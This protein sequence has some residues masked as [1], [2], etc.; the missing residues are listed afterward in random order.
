MRN[1]SIE[2]WLADSGA[3][4]TFVESL[5]LE[6]IDREA[7][8][9]NQARISAPIDEDTVITYAVAMENGD[10]F[11]PLVVYQE[12]ENG[13]YINVDGNH[14]YGAA[15]MVGKNRLPSYVVTNPTPALVSLLTYNANT[16]HGKP[17]TLQERLR[18]ATVLVEMGAAPKEIAANLQI[19]LRSLYA[20]IE[21][22]NT[23]K[24]M[25]GL[26][27]SRWDTIARGVRTRLTNV[28]SDRVL[29]AATSLV[30][31]AKL[32]SA[33]VNDLVTE[34][35]KKRNES[36]QMKVVAAWTERTAPDVAETGGGVIPIPKPIMYITQVLTRLEN[37]KPEHLDEAN[38]SE[39]YRAR[40]V[41]KVMAGAAR[42]R[43]VADRIG[44][45]NG[46]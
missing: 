3:Q 20:H 29:K 19:P 15:Q 24:R 21:Q 41:Q 34:V 8:Y 1:E 2:K 46:A 32:V 27:I 18:Q 11:P 39:E 28:R 35:N 22:V 37:I 12:K 45:K 31:R 7:S 25:Q 14:R 43:E 38:L 30:L 33:D 9:R 44:T 13:K 4:F 6:K 42:L 5:D 17:T 26:G 40:L 23:D 10:A 36:D 16:K